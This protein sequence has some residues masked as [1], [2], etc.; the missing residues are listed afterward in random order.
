MKTHYTLENKPE[1]KDGDIIQVDMSHFGW[2][3]E[4]RTGKIV[5]KS[6]NYIIDYWMIEFL[7]YICDGYK[8][9]VLN[10]PHTAILIQEENKSFGTIPVPLTFDKKK[11]DKAIADEIANEL[12]DKQD[13]EDFL[14]FIKDCTGRKGKIGL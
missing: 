7:D 5:G 4:I 11:R 12:A 8:F 13:Q 14:N 2:P 9:K 6:T 3:E 1:F 10:V